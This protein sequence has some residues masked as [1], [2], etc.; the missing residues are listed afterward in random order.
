MSRANIKAA[1]L[2]PFPVSAK[3]L[4]DDLIWPAAAGNVAWSFLQ[5]A[6]GDESHHRLMRLALL[7]FLAFYLAIDWFRSKSLDGKTRCYWVAD[8][9]HISSIVTYGVAVAAYKSASFLGYALAVIFGIAV[10][11]HLVGAWEVVEQPRNWCHRVMLTSCGL[12]GLGI[13]FFGRSASVGGSLQTLLIAFLTVL[14][15]WVSVRVLIAGGF[16]SGCETNEAK[17]GTQTR[18]DSINRL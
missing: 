7:F 2:K 14:I 9:I 15:A 3:A 17:G 13:L 8:A 5:V 1:F 4:F 18:D 16:A 12:V 6:I 10:I 11:G